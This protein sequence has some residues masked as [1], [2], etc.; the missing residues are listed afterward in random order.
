MELNL[1]WCIFF[2]GYLGVLVDDLTTNGTFEPYRMFT[3]RAEFRVYLRPD[4]ADLRLTA[5]G[6]LLKADHMKL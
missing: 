2:Q 3:S 6:T 5:K 4:N 1:V